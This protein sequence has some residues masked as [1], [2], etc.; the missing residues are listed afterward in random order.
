[1]NSK[2]VQEIHDY[3]KQSFYTK[4]SRYWSLANNILN[5]CDI[6]RDSYVLD[7]G[8]GTG[9]LSHYLFKRYGCH[10]DAMDISEEEL[11]GAKQAWQ[12]DDIQWIDMGGITFLKKSMILF[13][14]HR[15]LSMS[16]MLECIFHV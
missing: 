11:E 9:I 3:Y 10:V 14:V 13:S 8:C 12:E 6:K 2:S 4:Y 1:M 5:H 7:Y 15:S 16:I